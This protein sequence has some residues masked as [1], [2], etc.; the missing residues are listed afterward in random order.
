VTGSELA[1]RVAVVTGGGRDLGRVLALALADA[2]ADVA[3][4]GRSAAPLDET[5]TEITA[6]GRRGWAHVCDV[7]DEAAVVRT[8]ARIA[9]EAGAV[10]VL[11]NNAAAARLQRAVADMTRAEWDEAFAVKVT[12]AMLCSREALRVM[13]PRGRGAIVNVSG[14]TGK[15]GLA[16]VSAHSVAQAGLIAL[17]QSLAKEV[18]RHGV[19][20]NAV[21]PS[22]VEGEH[23]AR[24]TAAHDDAA[25][26]AETSLLA[27]LT[28]GSPLGRLV[29][30]G[31]VAD[32]V[33][34]LAGD[35]SSAM[36]GRTL[37]LL[38]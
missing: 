14:T 37:D 34:F 15:D 10:D 27:R 2:G 29:R 17:T 3:V 19:R 31:D 28:A 1:G 26:A 9:D 30:P 25:P 8:F 13:V 23:L 36:T 11:V 38:L 4:I 18:G 20:V 12:G 5:A 21:V 33:V 24:I 6:R 22:A 16:L 32:A 7:T 35:R